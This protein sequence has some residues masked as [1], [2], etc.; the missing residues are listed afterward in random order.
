MEV[1]KNTWWCCSADFGS[2][3]ATCPNANKSVVDN[4]AAVPPLST[5]SGQSESKD[6]PTAGAMRAAEAVKAL[7]NGDLSRGKSIAA[8]IDRETHTAELVAALELL[9]SLTKCDPTMERA[10][11]SF[12]PAR[13]ERVEQTIVSARAA[14]ARAK[15]E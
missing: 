8:I 13:G 1:K 5:N 14:L 15:G 10:H 4:T 2:H 11:W 3:D 6:K 12:S 9:L 7:F